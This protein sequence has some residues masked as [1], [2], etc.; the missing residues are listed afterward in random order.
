[1]A[2]IAVGILILERFYSRGSFLTT[3]NLGKEATLLIDF[4]SEKRMFEGEVIEKMTV[5]DVL[6][7][8][9]NTGKIKLRYS[10]DTGNNTIVAEIDGHSA[11]DGKN[12]SFYINGKETASANINK[13]FVNP[14]DEIIVKLK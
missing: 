5:L 14:G 7:A 10:V 9:V 1:M 2:V 8:S 12:F 13:I 11:S 4:D 6:N 3:E